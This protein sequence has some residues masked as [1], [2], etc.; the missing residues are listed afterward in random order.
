LRGEKDRKGE[1]GMREERKERGGSQSGVGMT[2]DTTLCAAGSNVRGGNGSQLMWSAHCLVSRCASLNKPL[3]NDPRWRHYERRVG[4]GGFVYRFV[5]DSLW[6]VSQIA[7]Y[8][9]WC[10]TWCIVVCTMS[11]TKAIW[12]EAVTCTVTP[13]NKA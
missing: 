12:R 10:V 1:R 4:F 5:S 9:P 2:V 11:H 7:G 8:L 6:I 3:L 13:C